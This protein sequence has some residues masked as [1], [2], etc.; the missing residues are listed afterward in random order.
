M[1]VSVA[2][3]PMPPP[4]PT[5]GACPRAGGG[6]R[7]HGTPA[8]GLSASIGV[9]RRFQETRWGKRNPKRD[10]SRSGS[11]SPSR[12]IAIG[13]GSQVRLVALGNPVPSLF[14]GRA[15]PHD[16]FSERGRSPYA[17][18][19]H[20]RHRDLDGTEPSSIFSVIEALNL[21]D[22]KTYARKFCCFFCLHTT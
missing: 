22:T 17:D 16:F 15:S 2:H 3:A 9:P 5:G 7:R 19:L 18:I 20:T 10:L 21:C 8:Q 14:V 13:E 12:P 1:P 6:E 11:G 4:A